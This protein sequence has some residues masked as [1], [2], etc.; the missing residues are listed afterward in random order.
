MYTYVSRFV[1]ARATD[2]ADATFPSR[3]AT[4]TAPSGTGVISSPFFGQ[5]APAL[6]QIIPFGAGAD[7]STFDLQVI[8]WR[9]TFNGLWIPNVLVQAACTLCTAVGVGTSDVPSTSRF[10]DTISLTLHNANVDASVLSKTN[11][12]IG[13][14]VVDAKGCQLIEVIFDLGTATGANALVAWV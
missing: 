13:S 3:V 7:N 1:R 10:V 11:D 6:A 4:T 2:S 5:R 9:P 14:F 12:T 8:G